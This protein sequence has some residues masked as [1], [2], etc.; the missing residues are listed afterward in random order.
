MKTLQLNRRK[1]VL[2]FLFVNTVQC[3]QSLIKTIAHA[4]IV[5]GSG[6]SGSSCNNNACKISSSSSS[7]VRV[8]TPSSVTVS[9]MLRYVKEH[10]LTRLP[11]SVDSWREYVNDVI[12]YDPMD[13]LIKYTIIIE[14]VYMKFRQPVDTATIL[15]YSSRLATHNTGV[16]RK[17]IKDRQFKSTCSI[18]YEDTINFII[19]CWHPVC[20]LCQSRLTKRSCPMCRESIACDMYTQILDLIKHTVTLL[21]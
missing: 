5:D 8:K 18:C 17:Y 14:I 4:T 20:T 13:S 10:R 7:S 19:P 6:S 2:D 3:F 12:F 15:Y 9:S 16:V 21:N 1:I 11:T